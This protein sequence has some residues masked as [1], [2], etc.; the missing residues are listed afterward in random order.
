MLHL[1]LR[2]GAGG[3]AAT[4]VGHV[5]LHRVRAEAAHHHG[6][7]AG[8]VGGGVTVDV[9]QVGSVVCAGAEQGRGRRLTHALRDRVQVKC[10]QLAL[11]LLLLLMLLLALPT[12][13]L[14]QLVSLLVE[15][16]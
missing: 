11:L 14:E 4:Q 3:E 15:I 1:A 8:H 16:S 2:R 9:G 7:D 12:L 6:I 5:R 13:Q 10:W